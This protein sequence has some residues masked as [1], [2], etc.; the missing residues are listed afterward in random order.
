MKAIKVLST[1]EN[2]VAAYYVN[3]YSVQLSYATN[4]GNA[5]MHRIMFTFEEGDNVSPFYMWKA[6][7]EALWEAKEREELLR[8]DCDAIRLK[9]SAK[10]PD[11]VHISMG[12]QSFVWDLR[13]SEWG[14]VGLIPS[15][16]DLQR[17]GDGRDRKRAMHQVAA[18]TWKCINSTFVVTDYKEK[19]EK[20]ATAEA[21]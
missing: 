18:A 3:E 10:T 20:T 9:I 11:V 15:K 7:V 8:K 19:E 1:V 17:L 5:K 2:S 21:V 12:E 6:T 16:V 4:S 14:S 13:G